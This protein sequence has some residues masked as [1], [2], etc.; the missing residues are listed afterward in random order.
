MPNNPSRMGSSTT[1]VQDD[2]T[3]TQDIF[4]IKEDS[5]NSTAANNPSPQN[6]ADNGGG[7]PP[8]LDAL[9]MDDQGNVSDGSNMNG[10][11]G[12][13]TVD[14]NA[15]GPPDL[16]GVSM[17]DQGNVSEGGGGGDGGDGS[18]DMNGDGTGGE[19]M[20][21][22]DMNVDEPDN[23]KKEDVDHA[24]LSV[25]H[26]ERLK[27][28]MV[29]MYRIIKGDIEL[30]NNYNAEHDDHSTIGEINCIIDNLTAANK[31]MRNILIKDLNQVEYADLLR[32]YVGAEK[33][34]DIS[35]SMIKKHF[36]KIRKIREEEI[37]KQKKNKNVRKYLLSE[38]NQ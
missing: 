22:D 32:V 6:N 26:K 16:D 11:D 24:K 10:N 33:V 20:S 12:G 23:T 36:D 19:D 7:S 5:Q 31:A 37:E 27:N 14:G 18:M 29:F 3:R 1:G 13:G 4:G 21:M 17:D 2:M 25:E 38:I 28:K 34:Y 35:I 9:S 8:D 30:L 15:A